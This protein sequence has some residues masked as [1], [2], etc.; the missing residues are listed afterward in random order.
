MSEVRCELELE[1]RLQGVGFRPLAFRLARELGLAGWVRNTTQGVTLALQGQPDGVAEFERRIAQELPAHA[2]I[3]RSTRRTVALCAQTGFAIA[4]STAGGER[5]AELL[6]DLATCAACARE[7]LD[8]ADRRYRYAFTSCTH[9][10]PRY[11]VICQLPYDRDSTT[12]RRFPMCAA[13]QAEYDDPEH[14]RFHAQTSCCAACGPSLA[15]KRAGGETLAQQDAALRLAAEAIRSGDIVA[16]MGIGGFHL[17]CDA[18]SDAAVGRLRQAKGRC[19]KPFAV[20][21]R[22]LAHARTLCEV[23]DLA[24]AA[25]G[26]SGAPIVLLPRRAEAEQQLS[27]AVAPAL[28]ELGV[29]LAYTP[30]HL[31][32]LHELAGAVVA[33]SGNLADEPICTEE[34]TARARL[35]GLTDLFLVHDRPIAARVDDSVVRIIAGTEV[36]LRAGR[37]YAPLLLPLESQDGP[38]DGARQTVVGL[39]PHNKATFAIARDA[40][41]VLSPHIGNLD[42]QLAIEAYR[43]SLRSL[44]GPQDREGVQAVC[45]LHPDYATTRIAEELCAQPLRVQHHEAHVLSCIAEHRLRGPV[46]GVAWDGT[47]YGP[48]GTIWGGEFL[49]GSAQ[50]LARIGLLRP[51]RLPGG[52][53][54][55]RDPRR[56][57]LGLLFE[58][59]GEEAAARAPGFTPQEA[60]T[61]CKMLQRGLSS[62]RTSSVGRLFDGVAALLGLCQRADYEGQAA[63]L[64]ESAAWGAEPAP[65]PYPL[66]LDGDA[67]IQVDWEPWLRAI[68][69]DAASGLPAAQL[70]AR[71]HETL[72]AAIVAVAQRCAIEQVVLS[73][74]CFQNRLLCE[75]AIAR[76]RLA[77]FRPHWNQKVPPNDGGIAVGQVVAGLRR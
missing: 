25:L 13:C 22:D 53:A 42:T 15:L 27:P 47:G 6:P 63:M 1:G 56:S 29:M 17:L 73:G 76:L 50:G 74:G 3:R 30:L 71:F 36:V 8:P 67:P 54:A 46:L 65:P 75:R 32:L 19:A 39:G 60:R 68:L 10:G 28:R 37:G 33:T 45:D 48:D 59:R 70:A 43:Q 66:R 35:A 23:S 7:V 41:I 14:R 16:V 5:S 26:G 38:R 62:P 72:A 31:L 12:M 58:L 51:F 18:R 69:D 55:S 24:A 77:G 11:S 52:D 49:R 64:L 9:C 44:L 34:S 40:G 2:T 4:P 20:M 21:V 57:A 61:L